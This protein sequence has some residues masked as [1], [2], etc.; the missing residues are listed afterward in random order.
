MINSPTLVNACE[1]GVNFVQAYRTDVTAPAV[2][3]DW[4]LTSLK[5]LDLLFRLK[6]TINARLKI[7]G[8]EELLEGSRHWSNAERTGNTQI[9]YQHN[10]ST[11][12]INDKRRNEGAGYFRMVL[13]F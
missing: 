2:T 10:F 8:G 11:G 12:V 9:V 7:V 4:F 1:A 6:S 3:S 5:E 13:A